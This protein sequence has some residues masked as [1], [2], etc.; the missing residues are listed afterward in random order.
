MK[1]NVEVPQQ[2]DRQSWERL[3]YGYAEFYQAPMNEQ[4]IDTVWSWIFDTNHSFYCLL[5]KDNNGTALGLMHYRAMV[6]P[7]RGTSIGFLDDLFIDPA[8]RGAGTG[9][10]MFKAL[11]KE[12][13]K[14][15]WPIIRWITAENNYRARNLYDQ[16]SDKTHWLTYQMDA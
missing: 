6:S 7:L 12:A 5:A 4:I 11:K 14:N 9:E 2:Q 13:Q 1:I 15:G 10:I 8:F 3:Y 16:I